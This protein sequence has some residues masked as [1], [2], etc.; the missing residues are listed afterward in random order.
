LPYEISAS[1]NMNNAGERLMK[2]HA[3]ICNYELNDAFRIQVV[4]IIEIYQQLSN[5]ILQQLLKPDRIKT[6][7]FFNETENS[8]K[9]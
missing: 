4:A 8:F 9:T 7:R 2:Q 5:R 3:H 6:K 1:G